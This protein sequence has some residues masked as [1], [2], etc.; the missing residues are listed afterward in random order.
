[1]LV[2]VAYYCGGTETSRTSAMKQGSSM[3]HCTPCLKKRSHL[4][5]AITLTH[6]NAFG[7]Y[8]GV[9][10]ADKVSN[11]KTLYYAT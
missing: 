8:F 9:N 6:V 10:V 5:L 11:Q 3:L 1:M 2:N 4:W 7:Y